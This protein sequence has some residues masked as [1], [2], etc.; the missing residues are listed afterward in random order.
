MIVFQMSLPQQLASRSASVMLVRRSTHL[1]TLR[2]TF[3]AEEGAW[4]PS[5]AV[6]ATETTFS[7][8]TNLRLVFFGTSNL[9]Q[10]SVNRPR[11]DEVLDIVLLQIDRLFPLQSDLRRPHNVPARGQ[12]TGDSRSAC[13]SCLT[14]HS[15]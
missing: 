8:G 14:C 9:M 15:T 7:L 5:S 6:T 13:R 4:C 11:L 1:G 3:G 2:S 10:L 12:K